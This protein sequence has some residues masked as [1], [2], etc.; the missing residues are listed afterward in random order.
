MGK[1]ENVSVFHAQ[2]SGLSRLNM[3]I[4]SMN[5]ATFELPDGVYTVFPIYTGGFVFRFEK[6]LKHIRESALSLGF[7]IQENWIRKKIR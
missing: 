6:H 7:K 5:Q 1:N 4:V 2:K 3:D